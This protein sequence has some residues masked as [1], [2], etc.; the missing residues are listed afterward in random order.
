MFKDYKEVFKN[1][2]HMQDQ[3]WRDSMASFPGSAFP[4]G[5]NDWQQKTLDNVND[6]VGQAI[7]NSLNLQRE[8]LNQWAGRAAGKNLKPKTFAELSE[9]ARRSAQHWLHDQNRLWDQWLNVIKA[10]GSKGKLPDFSGWEKAVQESMQGQMSLLN[11]WSEMTDFKKLSGKEVEKLSN[12]IS[13]AM[14]K[15]IET[16]QRL[17]SLWFDQMAG[18]GKSGGKAA[19]PRPKKQK[20]VTAAK[21]AKA[22]AE[23]AKTAPKSAQAED[24]LKQIRGIGPGLEKKLKE[25]GISTLKQIAA[26]KAADIARMEETVIRFAGRIE[27]EQWVK[28]AKALIS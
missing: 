25:N 4:S 27:R 20:P 18:A 1:L 11:Q 21:P 7:E 15:S 16:Q 19:E 3:L 23:S 9:D 13:K 22:A 26:W 12:Q 14:E 10:S 2:R 5:M 28:Q 6:L 17:W 8:W 24:D